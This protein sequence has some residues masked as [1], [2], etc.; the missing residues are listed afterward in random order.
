MP[1]YYVEETFFYTID[2][3]NEQAAREIQESVY[4]THESARIEFVGS[5]LKEF[6]LDEDKGW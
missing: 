6:Q 4:A 5:E 2:A 3:P 1:R